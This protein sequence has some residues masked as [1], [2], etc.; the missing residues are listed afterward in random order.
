M[1]TFN[2]NQIEAVIFDLDGLLINSEPFWQQ[3]EIEILTDAGVPLTV[4]MCRQTM[5]LRIDEVVNHWVQV[6]IVDIDRYPPVKLQNDII[7]RVIELI[8]EKGKPMPGARTAIEYFSSSGKKLALA[9]SSMNRVIHAS[10]EKL[11]FIEYFQVITS[12]EDEEFGKPHPGVFISAAKKMSVSPE[13]CL[14][15]EDSINGLIAARAA[16]MKCILIPEQST[17][18]KKESVLADRILESLEQIDYL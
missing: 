1:S 9:S 6:Y 7:K 10:L 15:L 17:A 11:G 12:A 18:Y 13:K 2:L 4:E 3:A 16:R 5:G 14:V 8:F